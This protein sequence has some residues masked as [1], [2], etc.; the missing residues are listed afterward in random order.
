MAQPRMHQFFLLFDSSDGTH[1]YEHFPGANRDILRKL[2]SRDSLSRWSPQ[3][4]QSQGRAGVHYI[5][6]GHRAYQYN[7]RGPRVSVGNLHF[8]IRLRLRVDV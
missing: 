5:M 3:K 6:V 7:D 2:D 1:I 8:Y 4:Y